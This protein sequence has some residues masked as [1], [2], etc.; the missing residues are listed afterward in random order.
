MVKSKARAS[1]LNLRVAF[2]LRIKKMNFVFKKTD[3]QQHRRHH[4]TFL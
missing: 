4:I 1:A 3:V 2:M